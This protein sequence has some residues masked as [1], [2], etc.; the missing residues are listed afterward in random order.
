MSALTTS[1]SGFRIG[2]VVDATWRDGETTRGTVVG[3]DPTWHD[4]FHVAWADGNRDTLCRALEL[5]EVRIV[6]RVV[7]RPA[8]QPDVETRVHFEAVVADLREVVDGPFDGRLLASREALALA[9]FLQDLCD[10]HDEQAIDLALWPTAGA[11]AR[12]YLFEL[13]ENGAPL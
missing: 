7:E 2:D 10:M 9:A 4:D 3:L 8:D 6:S 12:H 1:P 11:F 13:D 5:C